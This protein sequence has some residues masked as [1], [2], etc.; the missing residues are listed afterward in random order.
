[1][2]VHYVI[3]HN[4]GIIEIKLLENFID[5]VSASSRNRLR[6][7]ELMLP[8]ANLKLKKGHIKKHGLGKMKK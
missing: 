5:N 4:S 1:M 6:D 8:F 7:K 2:Y 3:C